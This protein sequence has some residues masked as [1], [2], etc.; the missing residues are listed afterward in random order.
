A[1]G[2]DSF[3]GTA[4]NTSDAGFVRRRCSDS[5]DDLSGA[6][7]PRHAGER[8]LARDAWLV[9]GDVSRCLSIVAVCAERTRNRGRLGKSKIDIPMGD[10]LLDFIW[11]GGGGG[12]GFADTWMASS[13]RVG[14]TRC[15][16]SG[17]GACLVD[18]LV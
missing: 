2:V 16:A 1:R 3:C 12:A 18:S 14:G 4:G 15:P 7:R 8:R 13:S 10:P 17:E 6:F 11:N 5:P 9:A